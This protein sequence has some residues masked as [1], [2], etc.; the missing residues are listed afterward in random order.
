MTET[1]QNF[2][3]PQ[4]QAD[5]DVESLLQAL[6][7]KEGSWVE[8][9]QACQTLQ[10][11][12]HSPQAIFEATGFEPIQQN[13]IIVGSQVYTS[14]VSAGVPE[15]VKSH[16]ERKGSDLLYEF[17]ILTQPERAAAAILSVEKGIDADEARDVAKAIKEFSRLAASP[18]GFTDH[19]GDA[20]AH[21]SW[22][23]ARQKTDLQERSR[24]IARGLRFV[25]SDDA[26]KQIERLLTDFSV[27]RTVPAPLLPVYRLESDEDLPRVLPVVGKLPLTKADFQAVPMIDPIEPFGMVK[28]SG[29]GAWVPVP[30]WQV[31]LLADD[32]VVLWCNSQDLPTPLPGKQENVLVV[33]DRAQ[34]EW[35]SDRYFIAE[36]ADQLQIQWSDTLPDLPSLG[37]VI[38]IMRPKKILDENYTKDY[39]GSRP[40]YDGWQTDE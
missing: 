2:S 16:F 7:R 40:G 36:D 3:Q 10:K 22:K 25:H 33:V 20:I 32:P 34:R 35:R 23:L 9:G 38:L 30:G 39:F 31:I 19:P 28:F 26:R 5:V 29:T 11:A 24:L 14:A 27:V 8:W 4:P 18:E 6:R 17:R 21:Q 37:E 13:Q 15:A 12:G 1:P